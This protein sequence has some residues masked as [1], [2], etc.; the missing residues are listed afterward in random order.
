MYRVKYCAMLC[1]TA[2]LPFSTI[3]CAGSARNY[4]N[5]PIDSWLNLY[6]TCY[7]TSV[8]PKHG[9]DLTSGT[10]SNVSIQSIVMRRAMDY[11]DRTGG[12]L[13]V[14]PCAFVETNS[15]C[16]RVSTNGFADVGFLWQMNICGEPAL[17][18]DH[19]QS[20]LP[21]TF[22]SF[23]LC[24]GTPLGT[25]DPASPVNLG[26]NRWTIFPTINYSSTPD[27]GW[28]WLETYVSAEISTDNNNF[29]VNGAQTLSRNPLFRVEEHAVA[30]SRRLLRRWRQGQHRRNQS[31][32][33]GERAES[34][35][36]HGLRYG[37]AQKRSSTMRVVAKPSGELDAQ[38]IS[39]TI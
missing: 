8:T 16:F 11:W 31:S 10:R 39:L 3:A 24:V 33:H 4:L 27:R 30:P 14:L 23:H 1:V 22:S 35:R 34:G 9:P 2:P 13:I 6:N 7:P 32:Q 26:A 37:M 20:F 29:R 17:T 12:L 19:F 21:E 28:T 5:A 15:G 18:R 36:W 25:Y 38:T